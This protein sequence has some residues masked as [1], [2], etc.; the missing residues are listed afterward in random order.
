M[1]ITNYDF[2]S[3]MEQGFKTLFAAS[4]IE[5]RI[6]DDIGEGDLPDEVVTLEM[7]TGG[8]ASDEHQNDAGE[9][10]NYTG[11]LEIE[12][13]SL[14]VSGDKVATNSNF[15]SRQAELV[16]TVRKLIEEIGA[17]EISDYW[18]NAHKPVRIM[19]TG[20]QRENDA[21]HRMT[22]LSYE[23]QFRIT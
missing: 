13:K 3:G 9:Y 1:D 21:K 14:R 23:I 2:E 5:L 7:D 12:I 16:A 20:T 19:P 15:R 18:P 4:D 22:T 17:T 10:D 8:P 6:A 11:S